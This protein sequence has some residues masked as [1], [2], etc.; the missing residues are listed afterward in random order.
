M[1]KKITSVLALTMAAT[2]SLG[3]VGCGNKE[4]EKPVETPP[5]VE[6]NET[7]STPEVETPEVETPAEISVSMD[8]IVNT[9]K[10]TYGDFYLPSMT[11]DQESFNM[12]VGLTSD[13]YS[14]FYA[15][16]P[17]MS[18]HA[19]RLFIVKTEKVEEVKA[20]FDAY[21]QSLIDDTMQYPMNISKIENSLV[22]VMEDYVMFF[23]LGGYTDEMPE[24]VDTMTPEDAE[25]ATNGLQTAF[26][27]EQ[28][29][30][31]RAA[32][33][34]LFVDGIVPEAAAPVEDEVTDET[35]T[36]EAAADVVAVDENNPDNAAPAEGE[37]V[38]T[39]ETVADVADDAS[40]EVDGTVTEGEPAE[41]T[42]ENTTEEVSDVETPAEEVTVNN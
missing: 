9:M 39:D 14:E 18:A 13:M 29:N 6:D 34:Q 19:D 7:P 30:I 2:M 12:L 41:A 4:E 20:V 42:E 21:R 27:V 10:N 38:N 3:L 22:Y 16:M 24:G 37:D 1:N 40:T 28:M 8:D 11:L 17:M 26:Y 15:E 32:L 31:G 36:D 25:E 23:M 35:V 5:V 33:D